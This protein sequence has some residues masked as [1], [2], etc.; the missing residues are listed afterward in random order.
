MTRISYIVFFRLATGRGGGFNTR[1][2]SGKGSKMSTIVYRD[3]L[4]NQEGAKVIRAQL[5]KG[6]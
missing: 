5:R 3:R 2:I 4:G 1:G 6:S